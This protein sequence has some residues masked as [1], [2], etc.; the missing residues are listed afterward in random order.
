MQHIEVQHVALDPLAA[1]EQPAE[2]PYGRIYADPESAFDGMDSTHL[3]S[4]RAN[5]A[6]A[7]GDVRHFRKVA[8]TQEGFEE[9]WRLENLKLHVGDPFSCQLDVE[10]ALAF[11]PRQRFNFY[12]SCAPAH[13]CSYSSLVL[14]NCHDQALNPRKARVICASD[15]PRI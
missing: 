12:G 8:A 11:Y 7:R 2:Q 15:W 6:D 5:A 14:R 1:I 4:N 9:A 13:L 10:S 3:V